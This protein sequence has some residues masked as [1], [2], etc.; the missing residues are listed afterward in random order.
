[1]QLEIFTFNPFST[2]CY[3]L[4]SNGKCAIID[5]S[6]QTEDEFDTLTDAVAASGCE[7]STLLLTHAHI[8]H[9]FGCKRVSEKFDLPFL[10]HEEDVP[11]FENGPT[12]AA[13]FGVPLDVSGV[14]ISPLTIGSTLAIGELLLEVVHTPGH[15]PG[16]VSFIEQNH[17]FVIS[18]DVLFSGSVGRTDLW[19]GSMDVL[20][21]SIST[22]LLTL[23]DDFAVYSGHGPATTIGA[24]RQS[25]PFLQSLQI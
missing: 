19:M 2:N 9:I 11:L 24:E 25:N 10:L 20:L 8:D 7:V 5:P 1:M 21:E 23:E 15:S 17:R 16:S 12:Q 18:G 14:A 22:Q 4:S 6:C 13:M 3:L